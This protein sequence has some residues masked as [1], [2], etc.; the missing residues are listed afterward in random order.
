MMALEA[1]VMNNIDQGNRGLTDEADWISSPVRLSVS[2]DVGFAVSS[3]V[4]LNLPPLRSQ[5]YL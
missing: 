2:K 3:A 1:E 5:E 4:D